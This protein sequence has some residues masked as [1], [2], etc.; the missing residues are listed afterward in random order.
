MNHQL[1]LSPF[2]HLP[3]S[4]SPVSDDEQ[5]EI[6][7]TV[8]KA[9]T[10]NENKR[11]RVRFEED[12]STQEVKKRVFELP[13]PSSS[14]MDTNE[15]SLL[16]LQKSDYEATMTSALNDVVAAKTR[17]QSQLS[18]NYVEAISDTYAVCCV[19]GG[20]SSFS[21]DNI[22]MLSLLDSTCRGLENHTLPRDMRVER[23]N[24]KVEV[25][26]KVLEVQQELKKM[27]G[28]EDTAEYLRW[29]SEYFSTPSRKF[30]RALGEIDGTCVQLVLLDYCIQTGGENINALCNFESR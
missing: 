15:K 21:V 24:R 5:P 23:K 14:K 8:P 1:I 27:S 18:S 11:K 29:V 28:C 10:N 3:Q 19:P 17:S 6:K 26:K 12:A 13:V 2:I 4:P 16:W 9:N 30:A 22:A 25:V 7:T 20:K